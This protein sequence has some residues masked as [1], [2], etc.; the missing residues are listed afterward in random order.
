MPSKIVIPASACLVLM[1]AS[2]PAAAQTL[3]EALVAAYQHNPGLLAARAQLRATDELVPQAAAGWRPTL[4]INGS[5]GLNNV[6]TRQA[7]AEDGGQ[8]GTSS[9][10]IQPSSGSLTLSQPVFQSG[11]TVARTRQAENTVKAGRARLLA[12]EQQ[13]LL[14][15]ATAYIAVVRDRELL[16]LSTAYIAVLERQRGATVR[17]LSAGEVTRTD[18]AQADTRLLNARAMLGQAQGTLDSSFATFVRVTGLQPDRL[19]SPQPLA[20]P[21]ATVQEASLAAQSDNPAVVAALFDQAAARD[22]VDVQF[23]ALLPQLSID[24]QIYRNADATA[25]GIRTIGQSLTANVT[26]PL[27]QGGAE[28]SAVRQA[29]QQSTQARFTLEDQA[30]VAAQQAV[31]SWQQVAALRAQAEQTRAAIRA[32][33]YA[34]DGVQ[35]EAV[36]GSRTT[37]DVLNAELEL[38]TTRQALVQT[39][40]GLVTNSYVL[41]AAVGRLTARDLRLPVQF[42]DWNVHYRDVKGRWIGLGE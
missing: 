16:R 7:V 30:R 17:R 3:T 9:L 1:L 35:R 41:A 25:R 36:I 37:Y 14:D 8:A 13:V 22:T 15:A 33:E 5:Y 20:V 21:I 27:F 31:S 26:V 38:L 39:V 32:A 10:Y 40:A 4:V 18:V 34:L 24:G 12:T 6:N 19:V 42:Y 28:Y 11:R 29:R 23:A 2:G